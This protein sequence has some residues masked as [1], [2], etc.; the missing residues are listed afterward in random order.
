MGYGKQAPPQKPQGGN[1]Q[2][3]QWEN[4]EVIGEV[5]KNK[6]AT[7]KVSRTV[8]H[9]DG[10]D[11]D[12]IKIQTWKMGEDGETSFPDKNSAITMKPAV[13]EKLAEILAK[14]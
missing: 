5:A 4:K 14:V 7:I 13:A 11:Q 8:F 12:Y 6:T 1:S 3:S 10:G 2:P 9:A